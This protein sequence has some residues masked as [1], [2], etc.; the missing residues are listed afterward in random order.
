MAAKIAADKKPIP[1]IV[2]ESLND[3]GDIGMPARVAALSLIDAAL[4]KRSGFDEAVTR[5]DFL[6]LSD[7]ERAFARALALLVL[8]RLG[9]LNDIIEQRTQ[10]TP[11]DAVCALLRI[12]LAQIGFMQVPD[13]AAVS[14]TV[15]LAER[16][17]HTRPFKGLINA[18]L[19]GIIRDGGLRAPNPARLAPDWL[20]QRWNTNYGTENAEGIA[21]VLTEEPA[22]DLTFKTATD[23]D[24]LKDPLQGE[25]LSGLTLRSALRGDLRDWAGYDDGVWWVQDASS[26]VPV[27]LLGD[28]TGQTAID[29]CAA[30]GGKTLQLLAKGATV[31]ALDRSKNRL[32]RVEENLA[33]IGYEADLVMAD[34]ETFEDAQQFDVVLLDAPCSATGTFRRQPDVLWATRPADIAKLA[35]VQHRLLDSAAPRVKPGGSLI[36]CTCSLEREEGETQVLAFLRRHKDFVLAPVTPEAAAR[37]GVPPASLTPEGWLRLLP[38]QRPGGQDG[39]FIARL[40]RVTG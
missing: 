22:T 32:K 2:P 16:E 24:R 3:G 38:H 5:S 12:G 27:A 7:S 14:T 37:A 20:F 13:F 39:F 29:L 1:E 34:A 26:A 33:R 23:L 21:M 30:P 28:L 36:Y 6:T 25:P 35:D 9:Q 10:K 19:R 17:S 15:K 4:A 31:T 40:T 18:I 11:S 8:R